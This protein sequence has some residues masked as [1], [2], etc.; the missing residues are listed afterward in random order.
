[1]IGLCLGAPAPAAAQWYFA[2][3]FGANYTHPASVTIDS[4]PADFIVTFD[5]VRFTAEPFRAPPYYGWRFGRLFG[6]ERRFGV[7]LEF[8]HL[9]VIGDTSR[10][11]TAEG[12]LSSIGPDGRL[13]M[14]TVVQRYSMTHGLNFIVI[15]GI[16]RRPL[17]GRVTLVSRAGAGGTLPHAETTVL[18]IGRE[19][20]EFAGAGA[21]VGA[22][23]DLPVWK[24]FW[25]RADHCPHAARSRRL[26]VGI[27]TRSLTGHQG[28]QGRE[29][30]KDMETSRTAL[31]SLPTLMS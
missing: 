2:G 1:L 29:D 27:D 19:Q 7:E 26:R 30:I 21:H 3:Y 6:T 23:I 13:R 25:H 8:I 14:D 28:M 18:G 16:W 12:R 4:P 17:L 15:N 5:E 24:R 20:Y 22:G 11:Y 31:M 9:K 10:E